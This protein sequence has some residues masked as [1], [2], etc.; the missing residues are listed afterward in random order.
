M[1]LDELPIKKEERL[2]AEAF[3]SGGIEKEREL[4]LKMK[5][6]EKIRMQE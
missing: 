4:R 2:F 1:Y 5:N 3:C 6:D